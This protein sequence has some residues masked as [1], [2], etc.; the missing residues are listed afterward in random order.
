M[1]V[2]ADYYIFKV[3]APISKESITLRARS[4][5]MQKEKNELRQTLSDG[6]LKNIL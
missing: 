1:F 3:V 2:V 5:D 6:I 4:E